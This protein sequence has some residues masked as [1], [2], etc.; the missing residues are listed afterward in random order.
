MTTTLRILNSTGSTQDEGLVPEIDSAGNG[1]FYFAFP[2]R[3]GGVSSQAKFPSISLSSLALR[4]ESGTKTARRTKW[5]DFMIKYSQ[6]QKEKRHEPFLQRFEAKAVIE[7]NEK[8]KRLR[9]ESKIISHDAS[10]EKSQLFQKKSYTF[11]FRMFVPQ[12]NIFRKYLT[13]YFQCVFLMLL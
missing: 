4:N 1:G 3:W 13:S 5:N 8:Q 9:M 11:N 12:K 10:F 7:K 2:K 6:N